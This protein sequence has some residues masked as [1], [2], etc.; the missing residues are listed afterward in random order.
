MIDYEL[1]FTNS[2]TKVRHHKHIN[3]CLLHFAQALIRNIQNL[4]LI[5]PY[6]T[7]LDFKRLV[8]QM[9]AFTFLPLDYIDMTWLRIM[10]FVPQLHEQNPITKFTDYFLNN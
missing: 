10:E 9:A 4:G 7:D 8:R 5:E 6:G 2:I 3:G 1:A